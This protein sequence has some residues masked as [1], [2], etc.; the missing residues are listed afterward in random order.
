MNERSPRG[1]KRKRY[2]PFASD[3]V[4][5]VDYKDYHKAA[6]HDVPSGQDTS[7]QDDRNLR[8]APASVDGGHQAGAAYSAAALRGR[9]ITSK[10]AARKPAFALCI[11]TGYQTPR[12]SFL[13]ASPL[14]YL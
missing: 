14:L 6:A 7:P 13:L 9:L 4:N 3:K 1:R 10:R 11:F 2:A 12:R 5:I 8:Q